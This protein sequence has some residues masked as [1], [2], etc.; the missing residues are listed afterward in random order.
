MIESGRYDKVLVIGADVM[1]SIIDY[2]DRNTC[3]LFGDAAGAVLLEPCEEEGYGVL[4]FIQRVDGAGEPYLHMKAGGSR[5]PASR[6]T[7][8][9]R[10]HYVYQEANASSSS[11]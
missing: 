11:P 7:V 8:E 1:S 3:V 5:K 2:T 4:D 6:E 10:E 9:A